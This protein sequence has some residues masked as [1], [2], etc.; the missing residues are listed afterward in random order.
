MSIHEFHQS[1]HSHRSGSP[2]L[3][4]L[5]QLNQLADART[6]LLSQDEDVVMGWPKWNLEGDEPG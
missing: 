6:I 1:L 2:L 4:A 3:T 5:R